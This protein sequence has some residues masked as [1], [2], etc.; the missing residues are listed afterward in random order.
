VSAAIYGIVYKVTNLIDGKVY[1]GQTAQTLWRRRRAHENL[2]AKPSTYFHRALAKHGFGN[3]SW[4]IVDTCETKEALHAREQYWIDHCACMAPGGYNSAEGGKGGAYLE[5]HKQRISAALKGR[6]VSAETRQKQS[7]MRKG[8]KMPRSAIEKF[9]A[10]TGEKNP[11][12]GRTHAEET[13]RVI[14]EKSKGRNWATGEKAGSWADVDRGI[15]LECYF[16]KMSND[17]MKAVHLEKTGRKIGIKALMRVFEELGLHIS[18]SRGKRG[19]S[20]RHAFIDG[21][22][23]AVFRTRLLAFIPPSDGREPDFQQASP[24]TPLHPHPHQD[25]TL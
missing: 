6:T 9:K 1:I 15:I 10:R 14:G 2:S 22:D 25:S 16:Q 17:Q 11:F 21:N 12:F 23:I 13:R 19:L 7:Q 5:S 18:T 3:F 24:A 8:V 4:E 20:E